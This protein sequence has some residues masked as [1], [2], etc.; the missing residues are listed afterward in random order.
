MKPHFKKMKG[1][2]FVFENRGDKIPIIVTGESCWS[3]MVDFKRFM[4]AY[5]LT[6]N[7][8]K[9]INNNV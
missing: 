3:A 5:N 1:T 6:K 4:Y 7:S 9:R 8:I 2:V